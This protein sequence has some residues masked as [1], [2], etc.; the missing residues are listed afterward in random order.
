MNVGFT[1]CKPNIV[2]AMDLYK[3]FVLF[4]FAEIKIK[5]TKQTEK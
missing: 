5:Q 2:C 3:I 1:P 4:L